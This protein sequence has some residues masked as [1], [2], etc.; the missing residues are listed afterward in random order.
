M[1]NRT[2]LLEGIKGCFNES[3]LQEICF[4]LGVNYEDLSE[5]GRAGKA[6]ELILF[7]ERRQSVE[8]LIAICHRMRPN[9]SW[10]ASS[11]VNRLPDAQS[12]EESL[13]ELFKARLPFAHAEHLT[14]LG[15]LLASLIQNPSQTPEIVAALE[16]SSALRQLLVPLAGQQ[17]AVNDTLINFG[18][19]NQMGDVELQNV[20]GRDVIHLNINI[21][22]P[23]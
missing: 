9:Y 11:A 7:V 14:K 3:E 19:G 8:E 13:T 16:S 21:H 6:R 1:Y 17:V 15:N 12:L 4:E 18:H 10:P 5:G 22:P 20:A 23:G 2:A